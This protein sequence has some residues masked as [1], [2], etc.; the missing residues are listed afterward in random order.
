MSEF[1]TNIWRRLETDFGQILTL[2]NKKNFTDKYQNQHLKKFG[3]FA[4]QQNIKLEKKQ[5]VCVII[6]LESIINTF[7]I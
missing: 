5:K 4:N 3:C 1:L 2:K 6:Q 7:L